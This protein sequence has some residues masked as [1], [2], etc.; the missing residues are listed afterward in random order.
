MARGGKSCSEPKRARA[1][2]NVL[3]HTP[4]TSERCWQT[5]F[6]TVHDSMDECYAAHSSKLSWHVLILG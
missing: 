1:V 2:C 3:W 5:C 6:R 4:L